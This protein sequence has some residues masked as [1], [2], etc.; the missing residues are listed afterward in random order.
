MGLTGEETIRDAVEPSEGQEA[1]LELSGQAQVTTE[2]LVEVKAMVVTI[3]ERL[4][5]NEAETVAMEAAGPST[6]R[7]KNL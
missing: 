7:I 6:R 5:G 2:T 4:A 3:V 1:A